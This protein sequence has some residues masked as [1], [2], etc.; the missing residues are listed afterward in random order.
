[1]SV[2]HALAGPVRQA[3]ASA[4]DRRPATAA[5]QLF[6][7]FAGLGA[8]T[9]NLAI[10]S[11]FLAGVAGFPAPAAY[12]GGGLAGL[13][14][15]GLLTASVLHMARGHLPGRRGATAALLAAAGV[16]VVSI[17]VGTPAGPVP[18]LSHLAALLLTLMV[19][20]A[21][22]W[23]HRSGTGNGG[24]GRAATGARPGRLLL[25]AFAGAVLVAGI[26]TPGLAASAAGQSAIPHGG[27]GATPPAVDHHGR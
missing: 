24:P 22:A 2:D 11:S 26:T 13:W 27:H 3:P 15:A 19:I 16:H 7:G 5:V 1:M 4:P 9:V 23:L 25:A 18:N 6:A 20:A 12:A 8:G 17:A 14:G 21:R 10:S